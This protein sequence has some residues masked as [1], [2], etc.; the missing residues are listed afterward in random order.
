MK[1]RISFSLIALFVAILMQ[2]QCYPVDVV[3]LNAAY[4]AL[5]ID[6]NSL[7]RQQEFFNAFPSTWME[8]ILTYQY[9]Y[10]KNDKTMYHNAFKHVDA[11]KNLTLIPD[12]TYCEK[13]VNLAVGG[14][15]NADAPN[16]LQMLLSETMEN[17]RDAMFNVLSV[18]DFL[19]KGERLQFWQFYWANIVCDDI[20]KKK[21]QQLIAFAEKSYPEEVEFISTAFK[22]FHNGVSIP[23]DYPHLN[24]GVSIRFQVNGDKKTE[25]VSK[26]PPLSAQ[27]SENIQTLKKL[28]FE[29]IS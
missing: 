27:V 18:P 7:K 1:K 5:T 6:P 24:P 11:L 9:P 4:Q 19:L 21:Y 14:K 16:Y 29:F 8:Y 22:Y 2:A 3:K 10:E 26:M 15:W 28:F 20:S 13:L 12:S 17:K 25:P 23:N